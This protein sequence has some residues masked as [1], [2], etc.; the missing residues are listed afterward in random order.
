MSD[1]SILVVGTGGKSY[2]SHVG[3]I[4]LPVIHA[5]CHKTHDGTTN[6]HNDLAHG[7]WEAISWGSSRFGLSRRTMNDQIPDAIMG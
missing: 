3:I 5:S 2:T 7:K 6:A 4:I 1:V